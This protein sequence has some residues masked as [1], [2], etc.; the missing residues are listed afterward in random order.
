[1]V[2]LTLADKH[3]PRRSF[4]VRI[5]SQYTSLHPQSLVDWLF[6]VFRAGGLAVC[7]TLH[8]LEPGLDHHL[9][10]NSIS[11]RT[12]QNTHL[13]SMLLLTPLTSIRL[14]RPVTW[15]RLSPAVV[16]GEAVAAIVAY[17]N[18]YA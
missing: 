18:A 16:D 17:A 1:M 7:D 2:Q 15:T 9:S 13:L 14:M 11:R 4:S 6:V 10:I 5:L 8:V 12:E 3:G